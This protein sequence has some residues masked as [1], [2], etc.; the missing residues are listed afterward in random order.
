MLAVL[1]QWRNKCS[2]LDITLTFKALYY[3]NFITHC[4]MYYITLFIGLSV[5]MSRRKI[6]TQHTKIIT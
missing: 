1:T 4:F 6:F 2:N 3:T 5:D